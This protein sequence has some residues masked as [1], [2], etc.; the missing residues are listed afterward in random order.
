MLRRILVRDA[1]RHSHLAWAEGMTVHVPDDVHAALRAG[2]HVDT[3]GDAVLRAS[4]PT[5][6]AGAAH[7]VRLHRAFIDRAPLTSRLPFSYQ[8]V[9]SLVRM[10]YANVMGRIQKRRESRWAAFPRWPLDLSAD[11]V[12][13]LTAPATLP[14]SDKCPVLLTHDLD[15]SEGLRNVVRYF[16]GIEESFGARSVN[17]VVPCGWQIDHGLLDELRRRGHLLGIHGYD[18]SGR[19]PFAAPELRR[20]RVLAARPLVE[21]YQMSGYRAPALLRTRGLLGDL[22]SVYRF[23]SSIPT[24]GGLFPA[25]NN[26]CAS[27][28]P[29]WLDSILEIPLSMPRDG[30]LR[31]L[32]HSPREIVRLWIECA[33]TIAR[34]RG[35]VVLLTH[36]E[37]RFSGNPAML[38]AYR[39]ILEFLAGD[40]AFRFGAPGEL[41]EG[42][43]A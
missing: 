30:S 19:T 26:G 31:F 41:A 3:A 4:L 16:A 42:R 14:S 11:F 38:S 29:F 23:D 36:C 18:H 24:A 12:A 17:F 37:A 7:D 27:A 32:G 9:P 43:A 5:L 34:S 28:R 33:R 22:A 13:D 39:Q 20:T 40:A 2:G 21:R 15:S 35:V 25:P 6:R 10:A 8:G 1:S